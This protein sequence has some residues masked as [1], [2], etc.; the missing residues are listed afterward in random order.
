MG[1]DFC[2]AQQSSAAA[3]P[4]ALLPKSH[5]HE[6]EQSSA[7]QHQTGDIGLPALR[8][9]GEITA[10]GGGE[11]PGMG[12]DP[13]VGSVDLLHSPGSQPDPQGAPAQGSAGPEEMVSR[14]IAQDSQQPPGQE[15]KQQDIREIPDEVW[16]TSAIKAVG[17]KGQQEEQGLPGTVEQGLVILKPCLT[18]ITVSDIYYSNRNKEVQT[19]RDNAK[20]GALTEVTFYI[21]LSLYTPKHGYAVMQFV[22]EKTGGRLS[23]GAGTLYG[24]LNSLQEKGWIVPCGESEGRKKEYLITSLGKEIAEKELVRLNELV[25]IASG[26][27]GGTV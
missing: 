10:E 21:L 24:A 17:Q 5:E 19:M 1:E 22:E 23:L 14:Q 18:A 20:G 15:Q 27:I 6:G 12:G 2:A 25:S 13:A 26:I 9:A 16:E 8:P 4:L 3:V 11:L 7:H